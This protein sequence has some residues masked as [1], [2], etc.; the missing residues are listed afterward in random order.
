MTGWRAARRAMIAAPT[1]W[2]CCPTSMGSTPPIRSAIPPRAIF[3]VVRSITAEIEA[4]AGGPRFPASARGGMATKLAAARIADRRGLRMAIAI[5][6]ACAA[7]A[8]AI[9]RRRALHLF[10]SPAQ[11]RAVRKSAGSPARLTAHGTLTVDAGAA[12]R[13]APRQE[14]AARRRHRRSRAGSSAATR[15]RVREPTGRE[16]ARG[17]VGL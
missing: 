11:S 17:L 10:S 15:W 4:M 13:A 8:G 1:A 3:R 6:R 5:A 12:A 9:R 14:P 16:I 2:C 7:S